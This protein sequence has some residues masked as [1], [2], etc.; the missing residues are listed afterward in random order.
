[1]ELA[2]NIEIISARLFLA[3][4]VR[5]ASKALSRSGRTLPIVPA[6]SPDWLKMKN[7]DAPAIKRE[8]EEDWVRERWR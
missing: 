5:S 4:S 2:I 6:R 8:A 1:M 7:A 3:T